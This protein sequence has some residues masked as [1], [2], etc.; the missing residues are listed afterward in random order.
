MSSV[1]GLLSYFLPLIFNTFYIF[2]HSILVPLIFL[3]FL[4]V[5][6]SFLL[7]LSLL[8]V[9]FCFFLFRSVHFYYTSLYFSKEFLFFILLTFLLDI[10]SVIIFWGLSVLKLQ[11]SKVSFIF[12]LHSHIVDARPSEKE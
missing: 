2:A 10:K 8:Y 11:I 6:F 1:Y 7:K 12:F 4:S 5:L 9:T 3:F